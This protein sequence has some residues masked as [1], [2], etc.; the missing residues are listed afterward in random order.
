MD[1]Q[2]QARDGIRRLYEALAQLS[3]AARIAFSLHEID[4]RSVAEVA[5]AVGASVTTTKLRVWWA[6]RA[7]HRAAA[8]DPVLAEFLAETDDRKEMP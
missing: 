4:G 7:L 3:P 6:R 8:L 1:R 2:A 5:A